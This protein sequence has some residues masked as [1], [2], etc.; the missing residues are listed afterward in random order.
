MTLASVTVAAMTLAAKFIAARTAADGV[1]AVCIPPGYL[2][3]LF[4][5]HEYAVVSLIDSQY[6][7]WLFRTGLIVSEADL[8]LAL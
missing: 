7:N 5:S 8:V 4:F 1:M 6:G 2:R 3:A